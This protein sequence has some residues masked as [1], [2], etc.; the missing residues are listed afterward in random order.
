MT[1]IDALLGTL[2]RTDP[3]YLYLALFF[4]AFVE[5]LFPPSPSDVVI[6]FGGS[7][8][9]LGKLNFFAAIF[10]ATVG[11]TAGFVVMYYVGFFL[12]RELIDS[13]RL[14]ILPLERIKQ[15]EKWFIRYG[16]GLV[17]ANRFLS[18]TRAV[19][20]FFVGVSEMPISITLP[21]CALS[22]L[23]WNST[24]LVGGLFLGQNWKHL[25]GFLEI[26]GTAVLILVVAAVAGLVVR[27]FI[28]RRNLRKNH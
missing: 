12:G 28:K 13:G 23:L 27:Y 20:S 1:E 9:G 16:Y 3:T 4:F 2:S 15:A 19:I 17:I 6:I 24:L 10:S 11:S 21:L 7:L 14:R 25:E 8:V 18:G 5:N 26:Y 22:A